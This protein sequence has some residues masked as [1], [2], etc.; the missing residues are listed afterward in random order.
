MGCYCDYDTPSIYNRTPVKAAR[1]EH[2]CSECSR[3]IKPGEPYESAF[4][5]WDGDRSTFKTC[6]HCLALREWVKAH[7]PCFC[8]AHGNTR[9]DAL[10]TAQGWS[11][12]APGLLFGAWRREIAIRRERKRATA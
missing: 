5:I 4:G 7:V 6:Q 1:K 2:R 12:E 3:A 9:Q 8:W 10:D 11:H